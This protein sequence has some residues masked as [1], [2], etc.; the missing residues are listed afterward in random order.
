MQT[1]LQ[2]DFRSRPP[3]REQQLLNAAVRLGRQTRENISQVSHLFV[4][5]E[6]MAHIEELEA[7][8]RRFEQALLQG[9]SAWQLQLTL[10]QTIPGVDQMGAA[11]LLVET[12]QVQSNLAKRHPHLTSLSHVVISEV[13]N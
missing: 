9:L 4:L 7:R 2:A 3:A 6:I 5:A 8:M 13:C 12:G 11:M 10:L 1:D